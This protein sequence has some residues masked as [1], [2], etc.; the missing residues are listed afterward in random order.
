[1]LHPELRSVPLPEEVHERIRVVMDELLAGPR[2]A[3]RLAPPV[4]YEASLKAV[5]VDQHGNAFVDLTA[6]PEALTGSSTEL[7]LAYGVVNSII[8]NCPEISARR[9]MKSANKPIGIFDSGVGGLTV[10]RALCERMPDEHYIYLGDT[11]RLP[12][13]T[14]TADT[15][16]RYA[17]NAAAHLIGH[18]IKLLVVACNTAS[19]FALEEVAADSPVPVVGVVRPGVRAALFTGAQR[20]GVIGTEGTIRSAAYQEAL[21]G[22]GPAVEVRTA[23]CPLFVPLAEEGWGDHSVT[24]QVARHYLAPWWTPR[25]P[26]PTRWSAITPN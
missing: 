16:R 25:A 17:L 19:S 24:D 22:L 1:M 11:A 2:S 21:A 7:M 12:Y 4:P 5:F 14:K 26:L 23:A 8:L 9:L 3:P 13:G 15:V 10:L 20:V 18:Q 6:P